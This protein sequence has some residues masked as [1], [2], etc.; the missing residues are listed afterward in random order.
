METEEII[1]YK[2]RLKKEYEELLKIRQGILIQTEMDEAEAAIAKRNKDVI[3]MEN[4]E[5]MEDAVKALDDIKKEK[6]GFVK[7][8]SVREADILN[9]QKVLDE[10]NE[11]LKIN[12]AV[13]VATVEEYEADINENKEKEK[14]LQDK[15]KEAK[16]QFIAVEEI[17]KE[18]QK[19]LEENKKEQARIGV[20]VSTLEGIEKKI[21][22]RET[23]IALKEEELVKRELELENQK[24]FIKN[25]RLHLESQQQSLKYAWEETKRKLEE[26]KRLYGNTTR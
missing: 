10:L 24:D 26:A 16:E 7:S 3:L 25:D 18:S 9:K 4:V 14:E 23:H 22:E 17:K 1:I 8:L 21:K 11:E 12:Q 13:A 5:L 6:E 19:V 20:C 2:E 15:I